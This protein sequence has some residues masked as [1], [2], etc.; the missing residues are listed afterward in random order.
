MN[1]SRKVSDCKIWIIYHSNLKEGL[2]IIKDM[3]NR[4]QNLY[5]SHNCAI[6]NDW[7]STTW[8]TMTGD[9][10]ILKNNETIGLTTVMNTV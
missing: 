2:R 5:T 8:T 1:V 6:E 7:P 4:I 9:L 10:K 3:L